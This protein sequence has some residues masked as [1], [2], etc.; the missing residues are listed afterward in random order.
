MDVGRDFRIQNKRVS[1]ESKTFKSV[2]CQYS[3]D[4]DC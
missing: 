4:F 3:K 2:T 1:T